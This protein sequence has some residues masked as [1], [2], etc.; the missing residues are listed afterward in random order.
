MSPAMGKPPY[1]V[2]QAYSDLVEAFR[3]VAEN[4]NAEVVFPRPPVE[5]CFHPAHDECEFR[6]SV[7]LKSWPHRHLPGSARLDIALRVL[8]RLR[9]TSAGSWEVAKSTVY[10]TYL[11]VENDRGRVIQTVHYDFLADGQ[12][13]HPMFHAQLTGECA[14]MADMEAWIPVD[15]PEADRLSKVVMRI[16]TSD[17]SLASVLY[18]LVADH[19]GGSSFRE[20]QGKAH[21]IQERLPQ[22]GYGALREGIIRSQHFK[23]SHWFAHMNSGLSSV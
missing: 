1:A 2:T 7:W 21:N 19:L 4:C 14:D 13:C 18:C 17:M 16:P 11:R 8:E 5:A 15:G 10:A 12:E 20:F 6:W 9:R 22:L 23:S 3:L